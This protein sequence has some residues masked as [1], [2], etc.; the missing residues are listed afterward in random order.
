M[1]RSVFDVYFFIGFLFLVVSYTFLQ[2][3]DHQVDIIFFTFLIIVLK[4]L[5]KSSE[6]FISPNSFNLEVFCDLFWCLVL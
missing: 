2:K 4:F 1:I 3:S 6:A 5:V